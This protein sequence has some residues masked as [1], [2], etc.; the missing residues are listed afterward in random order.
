MPSKTHTI[1]TDPDLIDA[2]HTVCAEQAAAALV[3]NRSED[4][5]LR[6]DAHARHDD[7][8][9]RRADLETQIVDAT[10][11]ITMTRLAPLEWMRIL[12]K[13]P[14]REDEP[15]DQRLGVNADTIADDLMPAVITTVVDGH[16]EPADLDW[17]TIAATMSPGDYLDLTMGAIQLHARR[18]AV[19]FSL[20]D[21]HESRG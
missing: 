6:A 14:A 13:H 9:A 11:T 3:A 7:A 20:T 17:P 19:P 15:Y 2:W 12:T 16:G 5:A 21:W 4:E 18:D 1:V 10:R 8:T